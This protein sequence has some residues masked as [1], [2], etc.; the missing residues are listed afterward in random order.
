MLVV[1]TVAKIRRA[2]FR[3]GEADQGDLPRAEGLAEGGA[4]GA[5]VWGD[6]VRLRARGSAAAE[7]RG[8]DEADLDADARGEQRQAGHASG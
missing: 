8:V 1:E 5:A 2:L 4:Q 3:S 6:S 7:D